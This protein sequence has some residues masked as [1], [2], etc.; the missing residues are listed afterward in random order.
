M[1][2]PC[3]YRS[4]R[5]L[6]NGNSF[7]SCDCPA[8]DRNRLFGYRIGKTPCEILISRRKGKKVNDCL[9]EFNDIGFLFRFALF[10]G[11]IQFLLIR[12]IGA[13][14][15]QLPPNGFNPCRIGSKSECF[16]P[17][18]PLMNQNPANTGL[19]Q[20]AGQRRISGRTKTPA[21]WRRDLPSVKQNG[22]G[23]LSP[24]YL[25]GNDRQN[26][27]NPHEYRVFDLSLCLVILV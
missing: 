27:S 19:F 18:F 3:D 23:G 6:L 7:R 13:F 12:R 17:V 1:T 24:P 4:L 8:P 25:S 2:H 9:S 11:G 22:I 21:R 26:G 15:C 16:E 20:T 10:T 5:T 14:G